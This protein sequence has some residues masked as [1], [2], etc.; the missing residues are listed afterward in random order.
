MSGDI[1]LLPIADLARALCLDP[2]DGVVV[3]LA[4]YFDESYSD[5]QPRV[6]AVAG[7]LSPIS[8]WTHFENDW[9]F[10]LNKFDIANPFHTTDFMARRGQFSDWNDEKRE[11]CIQHYTSVIRWRTQFRLSIGFDR[12]VFEDEMRNFDMGPYGFCVFEWMHEAERHMD[13][14]GITGPIAYVFESGSGFGGQIHDAMVW[15]KRRRQLRERYRLGSFSF[16]GKRD[17]LPLQAADI[18]AWETRAHH[19]RAIQEPP[20]EMRPSTH[21]LVS[22]S[23]HSGLLFTR[24]GFRSWKQRYYEY[25]ALHPDPEE[26]L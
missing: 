2:S 21:K 22:Q 14:Y 1:A 10:F 4:A 7:Y 16:A 15:I 26:G 11:R 3:T 12:A 13:R 23:V 20:R 5:N 9:R 19:S 17:V 8:Q 6:F 24:E 18:F 25:A